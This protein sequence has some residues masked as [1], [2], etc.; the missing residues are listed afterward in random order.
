LF[1]GKNR[2]FVKTD[3]TLNLGN[4][5]FNNEPVRYELNGII[6]HIGSGVNFGHYVSA[7]RGFNEQTWFRFDDSDTSQISLSDVAQMQ[8]YI[9]FYTKVSAEVPN[10]Q[11][12]PNFKRRCL[13]TGQQLSSGQGSVDQQGFAIFKSSRPEAL[14]K[15]F[16]F[17]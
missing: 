1:G 15:S 17:G 5:V 10:K 13:S 6:E 8:P 4:Y 3:I 2:L 9:L 7:W 12:P 11:F 14:S 16:F